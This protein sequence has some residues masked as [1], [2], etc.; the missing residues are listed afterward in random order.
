MTHEHDFTDAA[1]LAALTTPDASKQDTAMNIATLRQMVALL[2][3]GKRVVYTAHELEDGWN[4][5]ETET[6]NVEYDVPMSEGM[7]L[8]TAYVMNQTIDIQ[9]AEWD[10]EM[11]VVPVLKAFGIWDGS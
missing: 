3:V 1:Q 8:V 4:V 6:G 2:S 9:P 5:I 11:F 10:Y 7:A